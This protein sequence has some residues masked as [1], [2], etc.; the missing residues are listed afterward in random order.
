MW[1]AGWRA[2][3]RVGGRPDVFCAAQVGS[4]SYTALSYNDG[5]VAARS[6]LWAAYTPPPDCR[7]WLTALVLTC[8]RS[9]LPIVI[10]DPS[11]SGNP[12]IFVNGKFTDLTGYSMGEAHGKN[13]RL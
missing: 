8:S 5:S 7:A 10:S 1:R 12:L 6:L 9:A 4:P 13:C 3:G 2:D 11:L